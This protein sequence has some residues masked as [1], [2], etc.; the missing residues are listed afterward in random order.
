M[1]TA[2]KAQA[3]VEP[4]LASHIHPRLFQTMSADKSNVVIIGGGGAGLT[5]AQALAT[6]L[7]HSKYDLLVITNRPFGAS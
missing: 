1:A 7:D 3:K 2:I 6:K 5:I 4:L